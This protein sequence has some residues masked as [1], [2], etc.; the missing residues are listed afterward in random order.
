MKQWYEEIFTN[1]AN[2]YDEQEFTKGTIQEVD[3]LESEIEFD[4]AKQILDI[5]CGTGRH[6]IELAKRGYRVTGIDLSEDQLKK[7]R[8]KAGNE[9][10][11]VA[12]LRRDARDFSFDDPFDVVIMI[13]EG[14]FPLMEMDEMNFRILQKAER[15]LKQSGKSVFTTLNALFPLHHSVKDF[16]NAD[17]TGV[18]SDQDTFDLLTFRYY[19]TVTLVDD[20]GREKTLHCNERYY[21]PSEITWLLKSLHFKVIDIYGC[22]IGD[23]SRAKPLTA[24]DFEMLVIA[25]K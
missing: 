14:A 13:C 7:A 1:Y 5:G 9:G 19:S 12:F 18:Q 6:A 2:T 10:V 17:S 16:T 20:S 23:F 25:R 8:E 15:S 24:N 4:R 3:F 21:A 22:G 11:E